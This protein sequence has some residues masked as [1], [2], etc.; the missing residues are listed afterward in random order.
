ML[1]HL[2]NKELFNIIFIHVFITVIIHLK[3]LYTLYC[4]I[5]V[6]LYYDKCLA[7]YVDCDGFHICKDPQK[8]NKY[9]MI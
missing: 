6:L 2:I 4:C 9:D 1:P 5:T 8:V 7:C 3:Y